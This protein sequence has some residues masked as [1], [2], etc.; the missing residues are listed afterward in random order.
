APSESVAEL[1]RR[2]DAL[3]LSLELAAARA[4]RIT[5]QAMLAALDRRFDLLADGARDLPPR[6][7]TLRATLDWS[8]ALLDEPSRELLARL[9]VF[10]GSCDV[11]AAVTVCDAT[12][13][14]IEALLGGALVRRQGERLSML[15]TIREYAVD[16]LRASGGEQRVRHAHA[17]YYAVLLE[18][19]RSKLADADTIARVAAEDDNVRVA[20][21][22][23]QETGDRDLHLRLAV[24][25]ARFWTLRGQL[26]EADS[27]LRP[28]VRAAAT[29]A[30][31]L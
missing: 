4:D 25:I 23:T 20:L 26:H 2:L 27:W 30:P 5:P 3:P 28:A 21:R 8:Y 17:Q 13:T 14:T 18:E 24:A 1:C 19:A 22:W 6:Q 15:E 7:R 11:D 31:S 10:A 16:A 29:A 9:G 12:P